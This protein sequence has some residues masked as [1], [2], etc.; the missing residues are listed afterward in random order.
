MQKYFSKLMDSLLTK[1]KN[2]SIELVNI[3]INRITYLLKKLFIF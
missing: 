3:E 1:I 2:V